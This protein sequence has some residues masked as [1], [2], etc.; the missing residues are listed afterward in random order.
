MDRH[1]A[2]VGPPFGVPSGR[3]D[4]K[5]LRKG[6]LHASGPPA[7]AWVT[8][9][10]FWLCVT[11]RRVAVRLWQESGLCTWCKPTRQYP[12]TRTWYAQSS[13][14][15]SNTPGDRLMLFGDRLMEC[16]ILKKTEK[17]SKTISPKVYICMI[18]ETYRTR[19]WKRTNDR[20]T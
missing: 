2:R 10:T 15:C 16:T 19:F 13:R 14:R 4:P 8:S 12:I 17:F 20:E 3:R 9:H 5:G 6:V 18:L 7:R 1:P 11:R